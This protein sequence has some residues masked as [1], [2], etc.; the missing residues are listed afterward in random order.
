MLLRGPRIAGR[1]ADGQK[2]ALCGPGP[3]TDHARTAGDGY[4]AGAR[5]PGRAKYGSGFPACEIR[6]RGTAGTNF[7]E[8]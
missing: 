2:G 5:R 1:A 3:P 7:Q 8:T 6:K 4:G